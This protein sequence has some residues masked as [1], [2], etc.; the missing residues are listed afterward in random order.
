MSQGASGHLAAGQF[1]GRTSGR[2]QVANVILS[3]LVHTAP[4]RLPP[5]T[6]ERA[7]FCLLLDGEYEESFRTRTIRYRPMTLVF[8]PPG[9]AHRDEIGDGG[10]RFFAIEVP[11]AWLESMREHGPLAQS[12]VDVRGGDLVWLALRLFREQRDAAGPAPLAVESLLLEMLARVSRQAPSE[13]TPPAWLARVVEAMHAAERPDPTI[14]ALAAEAGVHP[15]HLACVFRR[16]LGE[17]PADYRQRL[18]VQRAARLLRSGGTTLAEVAAAAGFAD[19]S[20]LT[21]VFKRFTGTTPGALRAA[22][23]G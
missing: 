18:R 15:V 9:L 10:G 3:E 22:L 13:R 6:H 17:T 23:R 16:F 14:A 20:H 12:V 4:R 21:R 11:D 8:H 2:H 19:Q 1:Y 5:H 7:Y